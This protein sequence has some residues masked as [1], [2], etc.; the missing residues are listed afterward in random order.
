MTV[1]PR[2]IAGNNKMEINADDIL[3]TYM[4][5]APAGVYSVTDVATSLLCI[6]IADFGLLGT[7]IAPMVIILSFSVLLFLL[8]NKFF[9][10]PLMTLQIISALLLLSANVE[11]S[12]ASVLANLRNTFILF[13]GLIPLYFIRILFVTA[14]RSF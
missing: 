13:W 14:R 9:Q 1:V 11:G 8:K 5:I 4:N 2:V 7:F 6:F 12:L 3:L 10:H